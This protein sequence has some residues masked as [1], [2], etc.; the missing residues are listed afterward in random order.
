MMIELWGGPFDGKTMHVPN[1]LHTVR[2]PI[3][4]EMEILVTSTIEKIPLQI[5]VYERTWGS[6]RFH[7]V[8]TEAI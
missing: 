4:Q 1:D 7:Y 2:M 8:W 5:A 6:S 3:M